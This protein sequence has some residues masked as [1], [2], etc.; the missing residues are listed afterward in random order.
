MAIIESGNIIEG[1]GT[2]TPL[3]VAGA[4]DE[5][6]F[7]GKAGVGA[8]LIDTTN[9]VLYINTGTQAAPTWTKAGTQ[10]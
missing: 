5:T 3:R 10:S 6:T 9:A 4:P 8:L 1:S 2:G 7:A